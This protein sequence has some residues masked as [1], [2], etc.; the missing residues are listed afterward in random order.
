MVHPKQEKSQTVVKSRKG[1]P[2]VFRLGCSMNEA[3]KKPQEKQNRR[4]ACIS[5]RQSRDI[6]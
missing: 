5:R 4:L 6:S 2:P 1:Y 3:E